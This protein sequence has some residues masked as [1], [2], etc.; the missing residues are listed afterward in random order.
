MTQPEGRAVDVAT[1]LMR[2]ARNE[3]DRRRRRARLFAVAA[4]PAVLG[5][6]MVASATSIP[7]VLRVVVAAVLV[8]ALLVGVG[9]LVWSARP[10][11]DLQRLERAIVPALMPRLPK[12]ALVHLARFGGA[13]AS[14]YLIRSLVDGTTT[15]VVVDDLSTHDDYEPPREWYLTGN[16]GP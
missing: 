2:A 4:T 14:P 9:A 10:G 3:V 11:R 5:I 6:A 12:E 7:G 1:S 13:T 15:R 16:H 8:T